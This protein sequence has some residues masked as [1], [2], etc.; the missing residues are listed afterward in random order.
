[1]SA[2][3]TPRSW[4][5]GLSKT[6]SPPD[7]TLAAALPLIGRG[8]GLLALVLPSCG[9]PSLESNLRAILHER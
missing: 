5:T 7:A 1:M 9:A 6:Q 3:R 2:A 8:L 4:R